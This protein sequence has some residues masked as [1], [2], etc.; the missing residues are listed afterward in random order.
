MEGQRRCYST[1]CPCYMAPTATRPPTQTSNNDQYSMHDLVANTSRPLS[2]PTRTPSVWQQRRVQVTLS[3]VKNCR[4]CGAMPTPDMPD[5]PAGASKADMPVHRNTTRIKVVADSVWQHPS[6]SSCKQG[7]PVMPPATDKCNLTA[8]PLQSC[9]RPAACGRTGP[10]LSPPACMADTSP[11]TYMSRK[12]N[13][14]LPSSLGQN[15]PAW[16]HHAI[17]KTADRL[18][19]FTKD[20]SWH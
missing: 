18:C 9:I 19:T 20:F 15:T 3:A 16:L 6:C 5:S 8:T 14:T 11:H 7:L 13:A 1:P 4:C 17:N 10:S 2:S 12:C